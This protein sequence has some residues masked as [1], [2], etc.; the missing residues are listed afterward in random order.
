MGLPV[1]PSSF[2]MSIYESRGW[3]PKLPGWSDDILPFYRE[4]A[5]LAPD[6]AQIVEIGTAWG[7]SAVFLASELVRLGKRNVKLWCVDPWEEKKAPAAAMPPAVQGRV[8]TRGQM[9][10]LLEHATDE[11]TAILRPLR[12]TSAHAA[13]LFAPWT[14]DA[15]FVDGAHDE[16]NIVRDLNLWAG[17]VRPGGLLAGH[18][19]AVG[20]WPAV[21]RAVDMF[22]M[23]SGRQ[24]HVW[25]TI[26]FFEGL[27]S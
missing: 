18:D 11:E 2:R 5:E 22:A 6:G 7:R 4:L 16:E 20:P 3:R 25:E 9:L 24:K 15:V 17:K 12:T 23:K 10:T 8:S 27:K 21:V 26:W 1:V 13:E 19:Y 14:V